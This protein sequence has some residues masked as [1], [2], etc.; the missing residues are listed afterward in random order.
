M[1]SEITRHPSNRHGLLLYDFG[2]SPCARRVRISLLEKGLDWD[3]QTIDLSRMEQRSPEY[4]AIN[5]NGLV[6]TL[7][8][9]ERVIWESNVITQYLDDLFA[10]Q[11]LYPD[12]PWQLAQVRM[13]QAAEQA[14]AKDYRPLM[15]QRLIGPMLRLKYS[16]DEALAVAARSTE[17]PADLDWERR[18]WNLAVLTPTEQLQAEARLHGWLDKVET[19]LQA[20]DFLVGNGFSQAEISIYPRVAMYPYIGLRIAADRYPRTHAWMQRLECRP[21]FPRTQTP[22]DR[23]VLRL[24]RIGLL[25]WIAREVARAPAERSMGTRLGLSLLRLLLRLGTGWAGDERA[26]PPL[27]K[28]ANGLVLPAAGVT[29]PRPSI[30]RAPAIDG[31]VLHEYASAPECAR[32]RWLLIELG[33][34]FSSRE[35]DLGRLAHKAPDALRLNPFGELPILEH[36]ERVLYDS[37]TIAEYLAS[38]AGDTPWFPREALALARVRMWLAFDAGMHKEFRPLYWLH[39]VRP[40]L[41][42]QKIS[43]DALDTWIP[44][45]VSISHVDWLRSV[46]QGQPRFDSSAEHA[47]SILAARLQKID[48]ELASRPW[49]AGEQLSFADLALFT[50]VTLFPSLGIAIDTTA[51]PR[52]GDWMQRLRARPG[53]AVVASG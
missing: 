24:A 23:A 46:L 20:S 28:P 22:Q 26:R 32:L 9:G 13:W 43:P 15:Y 47:R 52:L 16:L 7:A 42:D 51:L 53:S 17:N 38:L 6:P 49:I 25:P 21:S 27:K 3:T 45:G 41:L 12:D 37:G 4:L 14:M 30:A 50:R 18:V 29:R 36:G 2:G 39:C 35:V 19:A 10:E 40:A 8:H 48:Q 5:P 11:P 31:L 1:Q 44:P 33:L 34:P